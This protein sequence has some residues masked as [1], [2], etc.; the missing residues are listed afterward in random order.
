MS[1]KNSS[2]TDLLQARPLTAVSSRVKNCRLW[3]ALITPFNQDNSIDFKSLQTIAV[4]QAQAGNGLL[5]LGSTGESLA[6]TSD[7]QLSVVNFVC[8]LTL[9]VPLMVAVGGYNLTEQVNWIDQCNELAIDAYLL[10]TPLYAKPGAV[11]Q[12]QWFT[13]LLDQAKF[14]CMLYN[15]PSRSGIEIPISTIQSV[16]N[17]PNCWAMKEASGDLNKF[18][19]YSEHCQFIDLY[20]GEDAMLPYLVA[21]GAKGLVSVCANVWPEATHCYVDKCFTQSG[22]QNQALFP[23]W[24]NAVEALFSVANPIPLKVLMH[25]KNTISN[26]ILR[27]PLT[28]LELPENNKLLHIDHEIN[29]W[30]SENGSSKTETSNQSN[31]AAES[32]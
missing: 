31:I 10:A 2:I 14:P 11:G 6:L 24:K 26:A 5:L 16:Q 1:Q 15:V 12:T 21:G 17:H 27:A 29:M 23:L 30:L 18:L 28:H 32:K 4:K 3:T 7:E 9:D 20:T 25:Q 22:L 13:A 8:Q 19:S